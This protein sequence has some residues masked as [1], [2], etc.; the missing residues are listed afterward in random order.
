M[1]SASSGV[2]PNEPG[3]GT[4]VSLSFSIC[5]FQSR[6]PTFFKDFFPIQE[7][8]KSMNYFSIENGCVR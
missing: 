5:D 3:H 8:P 1:T 2:V 7:I 4:Q 6:Y